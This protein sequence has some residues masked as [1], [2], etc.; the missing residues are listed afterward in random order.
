[1]GRKRKRG[2]FATTYQSETESENMTANNVKK[3]GEVTYLDA[4]KLLEIDSES[5]ISAIKS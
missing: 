4:M 2:K 5:N 3:E 1:M